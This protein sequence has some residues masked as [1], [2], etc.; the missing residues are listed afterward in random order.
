MAR[1]SAAH[2][3]ARRIAQDHVP[4]VHVKQGEV[5]RRGCR[6]PAQPELG[7][8]R[9][10]RVEVRDRLLALQAVELGRLRRAEAAREGQ[11]RRHRVRQVPH[12]PDARRDIREVVRPIR[13][14]RV[15]AAAGAGHAVLV[16]VAVDHAVVVV[17][18]RVFEAKSG[19]QRPAR[20]ERPAPVGVGRDH[21]RVDRVVVLAAGRADRVRLGRAVGRRPDLVLE[22]AAPRELRVEARDQRA[23]AEVARGREHHAA[24]VLA[25]VLDRLT[26]QEMLQEVHARAAKVSAQLAPRR[27]AVLGREAQ[28]SRVAIRLGIRVRA[29]NGAVAIGVLAVDESRRL[30]VEV[31]AGERELQRAGAGRAAPT[32]RSASAPRS[33]RRRASRRRRSRA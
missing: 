1:A 15:Q 27:A 14:P 25:V 8:V 2:V 31:R 29:G 32:R 18:A 30:L 6:A 3:E 13:R 28:R 19:L 26:E 7:R 20:R 12:Q 16:R 4:L 5:E 10:L 17:V 9:R 11:V 23:A 24:A 33:P 21:A 22:Q